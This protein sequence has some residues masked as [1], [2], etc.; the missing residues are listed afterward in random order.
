MHM[1]QLGQQEAEDRCT[2]VHWEKNDWLFPEEGDGWEIDLAE[3]IC[4]SPHCD[5]FALLIRLIIIMLL[6]GHY[7]LRIK[8]KELTPHLIASIRE[9]QKVAPLSMKTPASIMACPGSTQESVASCSP[10]CFC[11]Q[12]LVVHSLL[13]CPSLC[14]PG[15]KDLG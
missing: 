9:T 1:S 4:R 2:C 10:S 5:R 14:W 13:S 15:V 11:P 6:P 12:P 7:K 8:G 3:F